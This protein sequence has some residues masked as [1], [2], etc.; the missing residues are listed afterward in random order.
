MSPRLAIH[1]LGDFQVLREGTLQEFPHS[2]KTRAILAYLILT[3]RRHRRDRLCN[4]LWD[5]PDDPR[6]S[7][8]WSL[9]KLRALVDDPGQE[10]IVADRDYVS[11]DPK[12]AGIDL[13]EVRRALAAGPET[14]GTERLVEL[15]AAFRGELLED[16]AITDPPDLDLW[17]LA[18]REAARRTRASLLH[19]LVDDCTAR[20]ARMF[21]SRRATW[22]PPTRIPC[23]RTPSSS[24]R[25]PSQ[26]TAIKPTDS[27][28]SAARRCA[29][30]APSIS[31]N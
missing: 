12:G 15:A 13:F 28:R 5:V 23:R 20:D 3:G 30:P 9:S 16:L 25:S 29:V 14:L 24:A 19:V 7:L 22:S 21:S 10:R 26:G 2:R 27:M 8:R 1:V 31:R 11:F 4:L 6:G 18:E 17:L